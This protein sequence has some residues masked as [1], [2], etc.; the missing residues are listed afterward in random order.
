[1]PAREDTH[2]GCCPCPMSD[3]RRQDTAEEESRK[4]SEGPDTGWGWG[5]GERREGGSVSPRWTRHGD[6]VCVFSPLWPHPRGTEGTWTSYFACWDAWL[7]RTL[8]G[9]SAQG[10]Q[11]LLCTDRAPGHPRPGDLRGQAP[12]WQEGSRPQSPTQPGG[13]QAQ[14][15]LVPATALQQRPE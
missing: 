5:V 7:R 1:M 11:I 9:L 12:P 3:S 8:W 14:S 4:A 10:E 6:R 13:P 2:T 15:L